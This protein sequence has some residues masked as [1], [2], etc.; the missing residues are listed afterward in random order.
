MS[1]SKTTTDHTEIQEWA[2]KRGGQP[3]IVRGTGEN[4]SAEGLLRIRFSDESS[5]NLKAIGW[6]KFFETFDEKKL[7][8][9]YQDKTKDNKESRFFKIV[10]R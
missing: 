7:A 8:F 2:E 4:E 9:L 1:D 3:A 6:D 5:D 10:N